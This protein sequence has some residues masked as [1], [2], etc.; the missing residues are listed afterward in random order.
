MAFECTNFILPNIFSTMSSTQYVKRYCHSLTL[1][2]ATFSLDTNRLIGQPIARCAV[3]CPC[4]CCL[5]YTV[6]RN[7]VSEANKIF[8]IFKYIKSSCSVSM[9]DL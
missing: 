8:Y 6:V 7:V 3:C 2:L 1:R 4:M 9:F 5:L